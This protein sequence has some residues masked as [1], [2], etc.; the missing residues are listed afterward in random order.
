MIQNEKVEFRQKLIC[1][2]KNHNFT[3]TILGQQQDLAEWQFYYR[4]PRQPKQQTYPALREN[5]HYPPFWELILNKH[6]ASSSTLSLRLGQ[7]GLS[8]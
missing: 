4:R 2:K 1:S 5:K 7:L 6:R 3:L 8:K